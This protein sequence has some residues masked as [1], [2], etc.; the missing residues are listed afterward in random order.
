MEKME[1]RAYGYLLG[2]T[3]APVTE[4]REVTIAA[5]PEV[6]RAIASFLLECAAEME[7]NPAWDHRHFSDASYG[8]GV[9]GPDLIVASPS[10]VNG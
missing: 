1:I 10:S 3:S 8:L 4:L 9:Q 2:D 5:D 6:L 7:C